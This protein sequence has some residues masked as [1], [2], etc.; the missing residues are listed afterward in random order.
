MKWIDPKLSLVMKTPVRHPRIF[1]WNKVRSDT[2]KNAKG[3][4]SFCGG[5]YKKLI[6]CVYNYPKTAACCEL[7][8]SIQHISFSNFQ[9]F[10]IVRSG[11]EQYVIVRRFVDYFEK[12]K[13]NPSIKDIDKNAKSVNISLIEY[14]RTP[15]KT[16]LKLFPT[17]YFNTGYIEDNDDIDTFIDE[18]KDVSFDSEDLLADMKNQETIDFYVS[19]Q[20]NDPCESLKKDRLTDEEEK[21]LKNIFYPDK[22][23]LDMSIV[24]DDFTDS[25]TKIQETDIQYDRFIGVSSLSRK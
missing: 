18:H 14:I 19:L 13:K 10:E 8:F 6:C 17:E 12:N 24:I 25:L 15:F 11:L 16:N 3:V 22:K 9:D 5:R 4:C 21:Y 23:K 2:V 7:C 20:K 1:N